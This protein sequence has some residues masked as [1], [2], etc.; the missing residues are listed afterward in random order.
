ARDRD[1]DPGRLARLGVVTAES[2]LRAVVAG[3]RAVQREAHGVE[4]A[5]LARAR[6][7]RDEEEPVAREAVEVDGLE[8]AEGAEPLHLDAVDPHRAASPAWAESTSAISSRSRSSGPS[9]S[10]TNARKSPTTWGSGVSRV[11]RSRY[12][13]SAPSD[14]LSGSGWIVA[15]NGKRSRSRRIGSTGGVASVSTAHTQSSTFASY[16]GSASSSSSVPRSVA[17]RRG[18][19][20]S[21]H[22]TCASPDSS[23]STSHDPR[24]LSASPKL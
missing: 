16:A 9:P 13:R 8:G 14:R 19:G 17:R 10:R 7:T 2:L 15:Q 22:S 21:S 3:R 20:R 5:R 1:R 18:T 24:G 4:D 11:T 6:A 12:L 23:R